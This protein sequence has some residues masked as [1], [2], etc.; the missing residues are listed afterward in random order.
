MGSIGLID[1]ISEVGIV[2]TLGISTLTV[3]IVG[4]SSAPATA[5]IVEMNGFTVSVMTVLRPL[6]AV[7]AKPIAALVVSTASV[8]APLMPGMIVLLRA[9]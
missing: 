4:R 6:I 2:G 7:F 8:R 3:S 1:G 5:S 9:S